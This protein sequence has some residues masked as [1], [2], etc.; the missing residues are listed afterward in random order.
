MARD[1]LTATMSQ[2]I[3]AAHEKQLECLVDV[4][5]AALYNSFISD[6]SRIQQI[7]ANFGWNAIKARAPPDL[8]P[9]PRA[10]TS[11]PPL[12]LPS[13]AE[14]RARGPPRP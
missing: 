1:L 7:L 2:V 4:D 5:P 6:G 14:A 12:L 10:R 3:V 8:A 11:R 13:A 9:G